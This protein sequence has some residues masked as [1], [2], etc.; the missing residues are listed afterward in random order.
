[1]S[2]PG[3]GLLLVAGGVLAACATDSP[4]TPPLT[5]ASLQL[6]SAPQLSGTPGWLVDTVVVLA[7]DKAGHPLPGA[8]ITWSAPGDSV[9]PLGTESDSAGHARA[10]WQLGI[11]E[12]TRVLTIGSGHAAAATVQATSTTLHAVS[13]TSGDG[14]NCA[15]D[16][17]HQAWCWGS[18]YFGTLGRGFASPTASDSAAPV[19]GNITWSALSAAKSNFICGID[20][21]GVAYCWGVNVGGQLGSGTLTDTATVPTPVTTALRFTQIA[22]N[23]TFPRGTACGLTA[24]GEAWCWGSNQYALLGDS[25]LQVGGAQYSLAPVKV[26]SAES[27]ASVKVGTFHSCAINGTGAL[28]CWGQQSGD[29]GAFGARPHGIYPTPIPVAPGLQLIDV[30]FGNDLT[31]G[32][33]TAHQAYCWGLNWF[34][35]LGHGDTT[36]LAPDPLPVAGYHTFQS[37]ANGS[38]EQIF[39][40]GSDGL[41]YTWGS[42]S[43]CDLSQNTPAVVHA[44]LQ[45][46]NMDGQQDPFGACGVTATGAVYCTG[47]GT[48]KARGVPVK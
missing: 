46:T 31:C 38:F 32:L 17:A 5:A 9:T 33:S 15:L 41:A 8:A 30:A 12:G 40:L 28:F 16:A 34:G 48:V 23:G 43:C 44:S 6:V 36:T 29:T 47:W 42:P 21:G 26:Q 14:F 3:L 2:R 24:Q 18:N 13:L 4:P 7:L 20:L 25:T 22:T 37:L 19:S 11:P 10:I 45:F 27:F 39:A 1:M 35:G